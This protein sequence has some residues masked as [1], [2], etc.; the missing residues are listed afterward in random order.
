MSAPKVDADDNKRK[1]EAGELYYAFTPALIDERNR[2]KMAL[3]TYNKSENVARREQI[4][5]YK[6]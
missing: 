2:C 1:M 4:E 5:L 6:E 3:Q